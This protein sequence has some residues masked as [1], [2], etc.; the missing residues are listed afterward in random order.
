M[1]VA[2]GGMAAVWAA[3]L[4]GP[5]GFQKV[6]AIKTMLPELSDDPD[7]EA[8]F[9]DEARLAARIRHPHVAEIIDLGEEEGWLYLV[10][11]WVNGETIFTLNKQA[12]QKG[13][14]PLPLLLRLL[15]NVCAGLHSA[16][17]LRDENGRT[18]DLVHRDAS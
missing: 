3:R 7:F 1:P 4:R 16:H 18:L 15:S 10:M 11:E 8:M 12:R 13:G 9:L 6:V 14:I 2:Q 5:G 17:E